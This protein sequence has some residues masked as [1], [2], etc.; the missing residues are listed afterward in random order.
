MWARP[1]PLVPLGSLQPV[2]I[3]LL[4]LMVIKS[5][6]V[7]LAHRD[8]TS[9]V[10]GLGAVLFLVA[11]ETQAA[12]QALLLGLLRVDSGRLSLVRPP[13]RLVVAWRR[14]RLAALELLQRLLVESETGRVPV[15]RGALRELLSKRGR[16]DARRYLLLLDGRLL[17]LLERLELLRAVRGGISVRGRLVDCEGFPVSRTI[18]RGWDRAGGYSPE[19]GPEGIGDGWPEEVSTDECERFDL[20]HGSFEG[21]AGGPSARELRWRKLCEEGGAALQ[22]ERTGKGSSSLS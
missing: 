9:N 4:L 15:A 11:R 19:G 14:L 20:D 21:I 10:L 17:L 13:A 16:R 12:S 8:T 6:R 5:T 2:I 3:L 7:T 22:E 1:L 18:R